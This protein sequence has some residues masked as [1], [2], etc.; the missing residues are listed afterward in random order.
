[1]SF[2]FNLFFYVLFSFLKTFFFFLIFFFLFKSC[3]FFATI[4]DDVLKGQLNGVPVTG[5]IGDQQVCFKNLQFLFFLFLI[6]YF[7]FLY[8]LFIVYLFSFLYIFLF[9]F[10]F[11]IFFFLYFLGGVTWTR[12]YFSRGD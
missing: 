8:C 3:D 12:M 4:G 2:F 6:S 1:M 7:L 11:L 10:S 5:L 9:Y